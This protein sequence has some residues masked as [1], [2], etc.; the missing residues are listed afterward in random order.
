M[1]KVY[2]FELEYGSKRIYMAKDK[3]INPHNIEKKLC[4]CVTK[5][6]IDIYTVEKFSFQ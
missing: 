3:D 2:T 6:F 4:K 5:Q 1:K